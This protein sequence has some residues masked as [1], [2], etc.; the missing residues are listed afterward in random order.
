MEKYEFATSIYNIKSQLSL[1]SM[2]NISNV[3]DTVQEFEEN[4]KFIY[5]SKN[6]IF[7]Y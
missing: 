3:H 5:I 7:Y 1:Y 4:I 6:D 2:N